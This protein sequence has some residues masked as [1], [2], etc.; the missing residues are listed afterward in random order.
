MQNFIEASV[1]FYNDSIMAHNLGVI[2]SSAG[3]LHCKTP[4]GTGCDGFVGVTLET[5]TTAGPQA[6]QT[7]GIAIGVAASAIAIDDYVKLY[8][9]AGK[10]MSATQATPAAS[11]VVGKAVSAATDDGDLFSFIIDPKVVTV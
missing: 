7:K 2:N 1:T 9:T 6:I 5:R 4:T 11:Y 10:F 3:E 8:S